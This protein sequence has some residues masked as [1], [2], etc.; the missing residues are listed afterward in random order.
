MSKRART[1]TIVVLAAVA[2]AAIV[3][4]VG[5]RQ[6]S[7]CN[8]VG[9]NVAG[10]T[11]ECFTEWRWQLWPTGAASAVADGLASGSS[12]GPASRRVTS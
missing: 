7:W 6:V 12:S 8:D 2:L 11:N 1:W 10:E 4:V 3:G 5:L 9:A